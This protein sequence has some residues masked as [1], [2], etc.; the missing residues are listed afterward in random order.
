VKSRVYYGL[1]AL[2]ATLT[3]M[4][5]T[6]LEAPPEHVEDLGGSSRGPAHA[7]C[8]GR[9]RR[10]SGRL[11]RVHGRVAG[12]P[13][14][15][16][17]LQQRAAS[18][19]A[20]EAD[21]PNPALGQRIAAAL[22]T[23]APPEAP[24]TT[25]VPIERKR[26]RRITVVLAS[27]AAIVL[28]VVGV[29]VFTGGSVGPVGRAGRVGRQSRARVRD[30]HVGARG[31]FGTELQVSANGLVGGR[32]Y[33]LWMADAGEHQ[34][35]R[36]HLPSRC[37]WHAHGRGRCSL[38]A[39]TPFG[40]GSPTRPAPPSPSPSSHNKADRN[41]PGRAL[42]SRAMD[43][44]WTHE[45][46]DQLEW[47]WE[48]HLRPR[49]DG[50][51]DDEYVWE[52]APG[53]WSIRPRGTAVTKDAA[54]AGD[55]VMDDEDPEPD[56][57]PFTNV[58]WRLAHLS[59]LFGERA[60][61]HFGDASVTRKTIDWSGTAA[62]RARLARPLSR[63]VDRWHSRHRLGRDGASDRSARGPFAEHPMGALVL[64]I[65]REAIHHGAEVMLLRDLYR[66]T[67]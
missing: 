22:V 10:A 60:S 32:V 6:M 26:R 54:G 48:F 21:A 1:R 5:W 14:V 19:T 62:G 36:G 35:A 25:V 58:A 59:E 66:A 61:R 63:A 46:I 37:R 57:A 16:N 50:L 55:Y 52:P 33:A 47:H 64:H 34:D 53:C 20:P 3:E 67:H 30:G 2:R 43:L 39:R 49:L 11:R 41:G 42:A 17:A 65:N 29:A 56:P 24:S 51:T 8:R 12:A 23:A 4:G 44:D 45:A 38:P 18:T 28:A 27:A 9:V 31:A 7:R 15:V 40:C 13:A